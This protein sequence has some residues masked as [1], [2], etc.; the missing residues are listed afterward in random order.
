MS[1]ATALPP[2]STL[3]GRKLPRWTPA[4]LVAG[5]LAIAGVLA[6]LGPA[7]SIEGFVL[8][9]GSLFLIGQTITPSIPIQVRVVFVIKS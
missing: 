9:T 8:W 3:V 6:V 7:D 4:A 2:P 5:A 1:T